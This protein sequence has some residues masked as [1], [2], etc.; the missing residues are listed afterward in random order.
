MRAELELSRWLLGF[1]RYG[2]NHPRSIWKYLCGHPRFDGAPDPV[3]FDLRVLGPFC[4]E[5]HGYWK[6]EY[7]VLNLMTAIRVY[8]RINAMTA[9][10]KDRGQE[11][12][13]LI[14][15]RGRH[16]NMCI[17]EEEE[18]KVGDIHPIRGRTLLGGDW[19]LQKH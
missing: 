2:F 3:G 9:P 18:M 12:K 19:T 13:I 11:F 7:S 17:L 6:G 16:H 5:V 8:T 1:Y 4:A 10:H 14:G 15:K